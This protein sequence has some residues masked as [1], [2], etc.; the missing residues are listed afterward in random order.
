MQTGG[1]VEFEGA[2]SASHLAEMIWRADL[3]HLNQFLVGVD[4]NLDAKAL[5]VKMKEGGREPWITHRVTIFELAYELTLL[6]RSQQ[7]TTLRHTI[8]DKL[9]QKFEK[10]DEKRSF[11]VDRAYRE[12][13]A[14]PESPKSPTSPRS[15]MFAGAPALVFWDERTRSRIY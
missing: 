7:E 10:N 8:L 5:T 13:S 14:T 9:M 4:D 15:P 6:A 3:Y 1:R 12:R 2:L 11:D